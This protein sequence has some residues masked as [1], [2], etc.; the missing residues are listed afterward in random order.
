MSEDARP[1]TV[2]ELASAAGVTVRTLHHYDELG[3]LRPSGRSEAGYRLYDDEALRR[4][5]RIL[6]LR[7]LGFPLGELADLL[8]ADAGSLQAATRAQLERTERQRAATEALR[9]RLA[10]LLLE[11]E[12][13]GEPSSDRLIDTME[14]MSMSVKLTRIYTRK[15]DGGETRRGDASPVAKD[16]PAIE[17]GGEVDELCAQLGLALSLPDLPAGHSDWLR[18]IQNDLFDLGAEL[19]VPSTARRPDAPCIDRSYVDW[20]EDICDEVNAD[21]P[22]LDSFLL[23]GGDPYAAQLQVCRAVCRRAERRAFACGNAAPDALAYLNRLSDLLFILA[24]SAQAT[25]ETLWQPW[26]RR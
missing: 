19:S 2:G 7:G 4:L 15:G 26:S 14:A 24:R 17:A 1:R 13:S 20:L 5:Y 21:L 22:P 12:R 10:D 8:E 3:L 25:E 16:D 23:P 9:T 18:R 6:A 11:Q